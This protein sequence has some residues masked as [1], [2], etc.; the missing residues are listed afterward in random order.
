MIKTEDM[1]PGLYA[2]RLLLGV[3]YPYLTLAYWAGVPEVRP[4]M[5]SAPVTNSGS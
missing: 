4:C 5:R 3:A 2:A 1:V